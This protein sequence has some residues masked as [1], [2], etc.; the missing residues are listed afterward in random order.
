MTVHMK[1]RHALII[2]DEILIAFE[3]EALLADQGF[4]S[5]DIAESPQ[6]A[7][8]KAMA[9]RPDLITADYR[10][11]GGTGVEAVEAIQR[12]LGDIPVVF[13]TGN[14]ELV[15]GRE[16]PVVGKPISPRHLAEACAR[17]FTA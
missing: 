9:R 10:I 15:R 5:F 17:A 4:T 3:M 16:P 8:K 2:E 13:V 11:V 12:Q 7:L 6:D 14:A 1:A